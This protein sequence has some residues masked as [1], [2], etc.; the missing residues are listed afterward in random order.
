MP[1]LN[2]LAYLGFAKETTWGTGVAPT[3]WYPFDSAKP[4]NVTNTVVD[5]GKR[6]HITKDYAVI[7]TTKSATI[8]VEGNLYTNEIGH[9]LNALLTTRAT[10]G[11]S[12]Y[13]HVFKASETQRSLTFQHFN[14]SDERQYAGFVI[15]ELTLKGDAEGIVTVSWKAQG[16]SGSIVANST[17]AISSTLSEITGVNCSLTIDAAAN[18]NLF[19]FEITIKRENK[20]IFGANATQ[21]PSKAAQG[22]VEVTGKLTFDVEGNTEYAMYDAQA[23]KTLVLTLG[24]SASN[25]LVVTM[26]RAFIEKASFDDGD[27]S[28]RVDWEVRGTYNAT[29][30]GPVAVTLKNTTTTY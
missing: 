18:T 4:D 19:G 6:G 1:K 20:L 27:V 11:T 5:N 30:A 16:K 8:D 24:T 29:D 26:T 13:T 23:Y 12:P 2:Q 17:P 10:S 3:V 15:D 21:N 7:P 28:L 14:G 22:A 9:I 25:S